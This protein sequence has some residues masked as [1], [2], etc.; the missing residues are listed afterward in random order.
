MSERKS[1]IEYYQNYYSD[2]GE[3]AYL[4]EKLKASSRMLVFC[5][6]M[7]GYLK[8]GDKVLDIGCGD[9]I[10][11]ELMPEFQWHGVD[12]NTER[13]S[14]R[15]PGAITH[16]LM[17]APYPF[18]E[19]SF[20]CI[21]SSEVLEHLWDLRIVH[22]EARRLLKRDGVYI[23]STPNFNWI[24]NHLEHHKR[25]LSVA[26]QHWTFE[27]I[28][29]YDFLTHQKY[30]NDVGF[31]VDR[32]VGADA[33]YCPVFAN[34]CRAIRDGLRRDGVEVNEER[35]HQLVGEGLPDYQHTTI[36]ASKKA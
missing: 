34:V 36:I 27:H 15:I 2:K 16:D 31:V 5:E 28:R 11:A 18:E 6:W 7:R 25:I 14:R 30:L 20:D 10:F 1:D 4:G 13:A 3:A 35:L 22:K 29:H 23:I 8:P 26:E 33:H 19:R 32:H 17:Q 12:I 21:I 9:A 24:T